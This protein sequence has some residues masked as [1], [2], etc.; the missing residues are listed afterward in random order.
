MKKILTFACL[1]AFVFVL[2]CNETKPTTTGG[3]KPPAPTTPA[4]GDKPK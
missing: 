2:G 1:L 3:A 4:A